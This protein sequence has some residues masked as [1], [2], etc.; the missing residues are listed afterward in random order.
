[1]CWR[2]RQLSE[3]DPKPVSPPLN[4]MFNTKLYVTCIHFMG[5]NYLCSASSVSWKYM[6]AVSALNKN[7][8]QNGHIIYKVLSERERTWSEMRHL[9]KTSSFKLLHLPEY[10]A[11]QRTLN[12]LR[13]HSGHS[14]LEVIWIAFWRVTGVRWGPAGRMEAHASAA[15][16]AGTKGGPLGPSLC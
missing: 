5:N 3:G 13:S 4:L 16:T 14:L 7:S 11:G 1:M 15:G 8:M 2:P 12:V 10:Y 9:L 6:V